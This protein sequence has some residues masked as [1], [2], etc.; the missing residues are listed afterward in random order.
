MTGSSDARLPSAIGR[1][2][3]LKELGRGMMGVVYLAQDPA[4]DRLIA[5]KTIDLAFSVP[6]A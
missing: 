1:Y 4:L 3:I 6:P 5:L 2:R